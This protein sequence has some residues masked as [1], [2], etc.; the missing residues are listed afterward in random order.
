MV[1]ACSVLPTQ[2]QTWNTTANGASWGTAANWNP[3]LVPNAANAAAVLGPTI[4]ADRTIN[5]NGTFTVGSLTIDSPNSYTLTNNTLVF[6]VS[7]GS[8]AIN[9]TNSGSPTLASTL[10]LATNVV[11]THMGTGTLN[12]A[13]VVSGSGGLTKTGPGLVVMSGSSGNSYSGPTVVNQGELRL[14]KTSGNSIAGGLTIGNGSSAAVVRLT[15]NNQ[16]GDSGTVTVNST[17]QFLTSGTAS[18]TIGSLNL[19]GG[20]VDMGAGTLTLSADP[21]I[22]AN[23]HTN[24][25]TIAGNLAFPGAKTIQVAD[26][27]AAVD[28]DITAN[29][30]DSSYTTISKTGLGTLRLSGS[31]SFQGP[32][33][34][35]NGI[36]VIASSNALGP[37]TWGNSIASGA[38]LHLTGGIPV[39]EGNFELRGSGPDGTGALVSLS[40]SNSI[41][42]T[43]TAAQPATVGS[44]SGSTLAILG[45]LDLANTLTLTGAGNFNVSSPVFGAQALVKTGTGTL[46]FSGSGSDI[47]GRRLDV[48]GGTVE[49][50]RP[51]RILNTTENPVVGTTSGPAATLRLLTSNQ[52]RDDLFVHVFESGTF[53]LNNFNEGIA[54]LRLYGGTVQ[55]GS[56][57]LSIVNAGG[58]EIHAYSSAKTS[59]IT[60]N[61]RSDL[62]QGIT[63]T[64][65]PGTAPVALEISAAFSGTASTV[66]KKGTGTL[67]F[68][69]TQANT[70]TGQTIVDAGTLVLGKTSGVDAIA[71]S[72]VRVN[73]GGSLRLAAANQI[74]DTTGLILAGGTFITGASGGH[75]D[76]LGSMTLSAT[77]T[78]NLGTGVHQLV[79]ANSSAISWTGTLNISNWTG[80]GGSSGTQG[81]IFFGV[82]GLTTTQLAQVQFSG[83]APGA[84]LLSS[85]ELVP[86]PEPRVILAAAGLALFILIRERRHALAL[87]NIIHGRST[88]RAS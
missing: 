77:S 10:S 65:D 9:I 42:A 30:R 63:L 41:N 86:I 37:A 22:I 17:G 60:G 35:S 28:L 20:L 67:V 71:G 70:Y 8:A 15:A 2:A 38:A 72:S 44:A 48:L 29:I 34:I 83:F 23:A 57:L 51:G 43:L 54:G 25:A 14:S 56:G 81:Q 82:G 19:T 68:S 45:A 24:T 18:D 33:L 32:L 16:I 88:R 27:L 79:F 58:D 4:P 76:T 66:T 5:V 6:S 46:L 21:A 87:C 26:G 1:S 49:L 3:T 61:L 39:T 80:S 31:N 78:I 53:D 50:N 75:S 47:N 62:A 85:G 12:L 13:G 7:T 59:V 73:S 11:I 74:R 40:G 36:V 64:A 84:I 69:G 55:T 52:I